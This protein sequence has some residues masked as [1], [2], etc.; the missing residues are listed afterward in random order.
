M[1]GSVFATYSTGSTRGISESR[2]RDHRP[3]PLAM[4]QVISEP[5][6]LQR[7]PDRE[8]HCLGGGGVLGT[9]GD[10]MTL[11]G[12]RDREWKCRLGNESE[13]LYRAPGRDLAKLRNIIIA[14]RVGCDNFAA[15]KWIVIKPL[16]YHNCSARAWRG[17]RNHWIPQGRNFFFFSL[18]R[19][20]TASWR[21]K[22]SDCGRGWN[23]VIPPELI[24]R[25]C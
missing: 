3:Q 16:S 8:S 14:S 19:L 11:W 1:A 2:D 5:L 6:A 25:R 9:G 17:K 21:N 20:V 12:K 10:S 22:D 24:P 23:I 15:P 7:F 4:S 13:L 18:L